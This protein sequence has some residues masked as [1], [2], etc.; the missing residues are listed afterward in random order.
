MDFRDVREGIEESVL[1]IKR[2][3]AGKKVQDAKSLHTE[4]EKAL[5]D[6]IS[7]AEGSVQTRAVERLT[8]ELAGLQKRLSFSGKSGTSK[9]LGRNISESAHFI[10]YRLELKNSYTRLDLRSERAAI[11]SVALYLANGGSDGTK[12]QDLS[13][14]TIK[15]VDVRTITIEAAESGKRWHAAFGQRLAND[16]GMR[17]YCDPKNPEQMFQWDEG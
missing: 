10:T 7:I 3:M 17:K 5:S 16:Y 14:I 2:L 11:D 4:A 6:L 8:W 13:Q 12:F 9:T 15:E 1:N